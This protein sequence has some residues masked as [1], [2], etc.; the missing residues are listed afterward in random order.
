MYKHLHIIFPIKNINR[1][2]SRAPYLKTHN[3]LYTSFVLPKGWIKIRR[4]ANIPSYLLKS[5]RMY[6]KKSPKCHFSDLTKTESVF[7]SPLL[8]NSKTIFPEITKRSCSISFE[9]RRSAISQQ[10]KF[11]SL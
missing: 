6:R 10:Y 9:K 5:N 8:R 1:W 11:L 7:R 4:N 3:H 2:A